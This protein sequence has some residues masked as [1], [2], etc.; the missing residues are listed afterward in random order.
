[1][2]VTKTTT[3]TAL[4]GTLIIDFDADATVEANVTGSTQGTLYLVEVD[5]TANANDSVYLRIK[6]AANAQNQADLVPTWMF[7]APP[8]AK[9]CYSLPDGQ[10]YSAGLTMWCTKNNGLQDQTA[11]DNAVI[12]RLIAS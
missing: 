3:I 7:T 8:G 5:N 2:A 10:P 12:V 11:P 6:D 1:M 4:G 9:A